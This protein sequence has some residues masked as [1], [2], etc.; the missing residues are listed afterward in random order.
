[1]WEK[2]LG[3]NHWE[4]VIGKNQCEK[5]VG[6]KNYEEGCM[7]SEVVQLGGR[8]KYEKDE[9]KDV[10]EERIARYVVKKKKHV[11]MLCSG[12]A[13]NW[14]E[15]DH[16]HICTQVSGDVSLQHLSANRKLSC[17]FHV[18]ASK[19]SEIVIKTALTTRVETGR[20]R[21]HIRNIDSVSDVTQYFVFVALSQYLENNKVQI[22]KFSLIRT[23][24]VLNFESRS[25]FGVLKIVELLHSNTNSPIMKKKKYEW[26]PPSLNRQSQYCRI[27]ACIKIQK[28]RRQAKKKKKQQRYDIMTGFV[29]EMEKCKTKKKM[30]CVTENKHIWCRVSHLT[31]NH[32]ADVVVAPIWWMKGDDVKEEYSSQCVVGFVFLKKK[33]SVD[34]TLIKNGSS[35][36]QNYWAACNNV[37]RSPM[38][39]TTT[40][41]ITQSMFLLLICQLLQ[42]VGLVLCALIF[43]PLLLVSRK[44]GSVVAPSIAKSNKSCQSIMSRPF[45]SR[46]IICR[47]K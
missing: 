6:K 9:E 10:D 43:D 17:D 13:N 27:S 26:Y 8:D 12:K 25:D 39:M 29:E 38:I 37:K 3:K 28:E 46:S 5:S 40:T 23:D 30:M 42:Y 16:Q 22:V 19:G 1:H 41:T 18:P 4:K 15:R 24:V 7:L 2:S 21:T 14:N 45:K 35:H 36:S 20:K 11:E 34:F 31:W 44:R 47:T 33:H 32:S